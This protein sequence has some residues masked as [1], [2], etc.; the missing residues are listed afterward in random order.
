MSVVGN[1]SSTNLAILRGKISSVRPNE[2]DPTLTKEGASADAKATGDAIRNV[3]KSVSD[4][5]ASV[6]K[7]FDELEVDA[8]KIKSGTIATDRLPTTAISKG[9]TG[10]TT[11]EKARE[12]LGINLAN[13]GAASEGH[14]HGGTML[15][16]NGLELTPGSNAGHGGYIDFHYNGDYATEQRDYTS[17]LIEAPQGYLKLNN[18]AILTSS[19]VVALYNINLEF[20][21][22]IC[23]Y[24][25]SSINSHSV[26][27]I[28]LRSGAVATTQDVS[29]GCTSYAGY[30]RIVDKNGMN[31][32]YP[33]N[34][35]IVNL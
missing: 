28:Q 35:L 14:N 27:F 17:R 8:S 3:D 25:H 31:G 2:I 26:C 23:D 16:A 29:I 13:L 5:S 15:H 1:T 4:L 11:A 33:V 21:D 19:N 9:G 12:N 18:D 30:V 7:Q 10:A 24:S 6:K 22:G 34:I 20:V 32:S